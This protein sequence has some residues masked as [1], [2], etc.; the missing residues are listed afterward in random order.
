M[1]NQYFGHPNNTAITVG[2]VSYKLGTGESL[3]LT[4]CTGW[5]RPLREELTLECWTSFFLNRGCPARFHTHHA[6]CI[7]CNWV[8]HTQPLLSKCQQT[9]IYHTSI[10]TSGSVLHR[11]RASITT[12]AMAVHSVREPRYSSSHTRL[13]SRQPLR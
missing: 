3:Q 11:E 9:P 6:A 2:V 5:K 1:K 13:I 10:C 7:H 4:C 8:L 12:L